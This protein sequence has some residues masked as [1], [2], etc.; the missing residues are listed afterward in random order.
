MKTNGLSVGF[1]LA[2]M[3]GFTADLAAQNRL[4]PFGSRNKQ[5][6]EH[7]F[8]LTQKAG[9]WLILCAS[10]VGDEG[11][12]QARML[13]DELSQKQKFKCYL[14]RQSFD[15]SGTVTGLGY[16]EDEHVDENGKVIVQP[17]KMR[18]LRDSQFDE[19]AVLLGDFPTVDDARAQQALELVKRLHPDALGELHAGETSHQR[20]RVWRDSAKAVSGANDGKGPMRAAFMI[21]NPLLPE[22]YFSAQK[23]DKFVLDLNRQVRHSLLECP[24]LYSVRVATFRG[25]T[26]FDLQKMRQDDLEEKF[27]L[28]NNKPIESSKLAD[29]ADKAHQLTAE[30]RRLDV[31]AY[32]FHDRHESYVCVGSFDWATRKDPDGNIVQ[33]PAIVDTIK[34][35][36]GDVG[37]L[38]NHPGTVEPK[39]LPKLRAQGI[40]F[41]VQPVP[42]IAPKPPQDHR[43]ARKK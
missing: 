41:D 33:N 34:M 8:E 43:T 12:I 1:F 20:L 14:H 36:R 15:F 35:F 38:P 32:E 39:S 18:A 37:H 42:V 27:R 21:P 2:L 17:K 40:V 7:D 3:L 29:A 10:F 6:V 22:E 4:F 16:D 31:E 26:T 28:R 11:E 23:I 25:D 24:G 13:C 9:P 19:I 30:L 5:S